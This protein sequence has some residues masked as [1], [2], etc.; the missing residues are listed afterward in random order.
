[1]S[2]CPT[3][4]SCRKQ[5]QADCIAV[6]PGKWEVGSFLTPKD[7]SFIDYNTERMTIYDPDT[8]LRLPQRRSFLS[9]EYFNSGCLPIYCTS[10]DR[11]CGMKNQTPVQSKETIAMFDQAFASTDPFI[12]AYSPAA[13]AGGKGVHN[14]TY[15]RQ[16]PNFGA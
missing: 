16:M 10:S 13:C 9:P 12:G 11:S 5:T 8:H 3:Y 15:G 1:M 6:A 14:S 7:G 2:A 4:P